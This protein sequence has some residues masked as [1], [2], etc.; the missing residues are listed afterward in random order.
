MNKKITKNE[1]I[2]VAGS[3]GMVGSSI[4]RELRRN[5]YGSKKYGGEL[6]TPKRKDLNLLDKELVNTW[7][8]NKKP[9]IVICAAAKV[10]GILANTTSP[11]DFL[12]ENLQIQNNIITAAWKNNV[13]RLLFLGSSCIYPKYANQPLKEEYLLNGDLEETNQ[14]YAIAKIAGLKLCE[15]LSK[16]YQFDA[17]SLMPT[18]LYGPGDNYHPQNSHVMA[19]LIRKFDEAIK[20]NLNSVTC[21]GSGSPL[22][23][24]MHVDDLS[25]AI[26]FCLEH[27]NPIDKEAPVDDKKNPLYFLN[28]GTGKEISIKSL[29]EM[30]A[31][32]FG[33]KGTIKWDKSKPDGTPRKKLNVDK[34]NK[35][36]WHAKIDLKK[37]IEETIIE[38]KKNFSIQI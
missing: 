4:C 12:I 20:N 30:I 13:K 6:L 29:S 34:I 18:N 7:F 33:F 3:S 27:W 21:W 36:G 35:L 9:S 14:W 32:E 1:K 22:R 23:E 37:G 10:G 25:K 19:A 24:F 2:F 16:Q 8:K 15:S 26:L 28:V 5:N 31:N 11:A 38:Y 17:I